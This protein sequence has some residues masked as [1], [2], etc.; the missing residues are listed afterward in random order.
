[1]GSFKPLLTANGFALIQLALQSALDGGST[2]VCVVTGREHELVRNALR[3]IVPDSERGQNGNTESRVFFI[4]N[5]D[6]AT[7]DMLHSIKLGLRALLSDGRLAADLQPPARQDTRLAT[8]TSDAP[9]A[10][11]L[12]PAD[13]AAVS[14]QTFGLLRDCALS[15]AAAVIHPYFKADRG[16]PVLVKRACFEAIL[17][18]DC[19]GG[20]KE[21][22]KPFASQ[23]VAV[24]DKG[25]L[26]DADT[27]ADFEAL[28]TYVRGHKGIAR[29]LTDALLERSQTPRHIR[30]HCR[31]VSELA[32]R[33]AQRLND[34]GEC[35]DSELCRSA[36]AVHD[37]ERLQKQHAR[38]A[39]NILCEQGYEA[40]AQ[41]VDDHDSALAGHLDPERF[42]ES[43]VVFVADKLVKETQIVTLAQRYQTALEEFDATTPVG[44]RIRTDI[45]VCQRALT[46]YEQLTGDYICPQPTDIQTIS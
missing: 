6:F 30:A 18:F 38:V 22:L 34:Q 46:R 32:L 17:D 25:I 20:L 4:H 10:I 31:A 2:R 1:M 21:A 36:A 37:S 13:I 28:A 19:G 16:H 35:L 24:A 29:G 9:D 14:P 43:L 5:P 41:V 11:Y 39:A 12:L 27:P 42:T 7:T 15:S 3:D 8:V 44:Q 45:A 26:L 40:L 23:S 33:M